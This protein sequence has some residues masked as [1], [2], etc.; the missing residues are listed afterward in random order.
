R[1]NWPPRRRDARPTRKP[2]SNWC[3]SSPTSRTARSTRA[4]TVTA[5]R[6]PCRSR[7]A[8]GRSSRNEKIHEGHEGTRKERDKEGLLSCSFVPFVDESWKAFMPPFTITS[9]RPQEWATVFDLMFR[10]IPEPEREVRV[11]NAQRLAES[12][13]LNPEGIFVARE[14]GRSVGAV[15][16][17]AVPGASALFW[18][19]QTVAETDAA[20]VTS[21]LLEHA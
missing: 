12:G 5:N 20:L 7:G 17:L 10:H 15:V 3:A 4:A 14:R 16:C 19:P 9:A 8:N 18:P 2:S 13:E 21:N 11:G 6:Q 1:R